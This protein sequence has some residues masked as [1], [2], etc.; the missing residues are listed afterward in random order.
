MIELR[1][2]TAGGFREASLALAPGDRCRLL[3]EAESDLTLFLRLLV[4]TAHPIEGEVV[5]FGRPLAGLPEEEALALLSRVG[6]VWPGGGFISNLK[7]WENLLLPLWYHG[8]AG[9][10]R[11]EAEVVELL[12]RL[13]L[14]PDRVAFFLGALPGTLPAKEQRLLGLV[15]A[16]LQDTEVMIYA[17]LFEGLDERT[18][19]LVRDETFRHHARRPGRTS[20]YVAAGAQGLPEPF[21]GRSLR[22]GPDGGFAPWP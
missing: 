16:L 7:T 14:G 20:L 21:E 8:D 22:Q 4:G 11:R 13:G 6:L 10:A 5:L 15:R 19:T 9:A 1:A 2:V 12:G 3:L 18:R 17:G